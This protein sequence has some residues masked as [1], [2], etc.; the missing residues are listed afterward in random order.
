MS[1]LI[2]KI[3]EGKKRSREQLAALPVEE[4]IALIAKMRDR[5]LSIAASQ[6]TPIVNRRTNRRPRKPAG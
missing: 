4:K 5:S 6:I 1:E 2:K 3:L